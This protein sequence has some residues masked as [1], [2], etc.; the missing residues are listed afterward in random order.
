MSEINLCTS[1]ERLPFAVAHRGGISP[2]HPENTIGGFVQAVA[3]GYRR[4]ET[5]VHATRKGE[6]VVVHGRTANREEGPGFENEFVFVGDK[7]IPIVDL[8][9]NKRR[10]I[11]SQTGLYIPSLNEVLD[12]GTHP[13]DEIFWNIDAKSAAAI[14]PLVT[15]LKKRGILPR[16]CLATDELQIVQL[17]SQLPAG[18]PTALVLSELVELYKFSQ[19]NGTDSANLSLPASGRAQVPMTYNGIPVATDVKFLKAAHE[20]GVP[21]DVWT[22]NDGPS[23]QQLLDLGVDGIMSDDLHTLKTVLEANNRSLV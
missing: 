2:E 22:V 4:L 9:D 11:E 6:L 18:T 14:D 7:Q 17:R 19:A 13:N 21:V 20:L 12:A 10:A 16:V 5:D 23:M 3:L 8:D 15:L 1:P